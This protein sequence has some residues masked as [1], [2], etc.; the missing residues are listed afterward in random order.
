MVNNDDFETF[1]RAYPRRIAKGAAREKFAKAIKLT[2]LETMLEAIAAYI[3]HKPERIDFKHPA[4][5][6]HQE[7]WDDEWESEKPKLT[8]IAAAAERL[9][10]NGSGSNYQPNHYDQRLPAIT[11]Y[12][13]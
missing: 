5:W 7:C 9:L 13:S 12:Q 4:T 1:W 8:G 2:T 10:S 11:K 6:L 3:G